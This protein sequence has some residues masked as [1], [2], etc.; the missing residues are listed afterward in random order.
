MSIVSPIVNVVEINIPRKTA[1]KKRLDLIPGCKETARSA[2]F[3]VLGLSNRPVCKHG[4]KLCEGR[5]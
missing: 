1:P 2:S 3:L 4:V 5:F